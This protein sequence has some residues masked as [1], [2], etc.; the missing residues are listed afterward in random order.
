MH[1]EVIDENY[2]W[3]IHKYDDDKKQIVAT[4]GPP[5]TCAQEPRF[6]ANPDSD[7]EEDGIILSTIY[8]FYNQKSSIVVIDP[9]TM[10]TL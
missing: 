2:R 5:M 3:P 9:R 7:N 4:W 1:Q 6:I 8:D 10:K